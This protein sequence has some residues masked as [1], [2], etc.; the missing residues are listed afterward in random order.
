MT[1]APSPASPATGWTLT[2]DAWNRLVKVANGTTT[3]AEY[4]YDGRN[5]RTVKMKYS[6][7][8]LSETRHFYYNDG[9]QCLEERVNAG[10]TAACQYV[11]GDRYVDDLVLRDRDSDYAYGVDER[12]Y[13]MQDPNWNVIALGETDGDV[14]QRFSYKAYG[15]PEIRRSNFVPYG[16]SYAWDILYTGRHYDLE[17]GRYHYRNRYHHAQLGRFLSRDPI[18]Y[19]SKDFNLYRYVHNSPTNS[20]DPS[21]TSD[22]GWPGPPLSCPSKCTQADIDA[23]NAGYNQCVLIVYNTYKPLFDNWEKTRD[24]WLAEAGKQESQCLANCKANHPDNGG[25]RAACQ[26]GCWFAY[27]ALKANIWGAWSA[28][29][30][31]LTAQETADYLKCGY[32]NPCHGKKAGDIK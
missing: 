27:K 3:I 16:N 17:T 10:T 2:Y 26:L 1:T 21:G 8:Q 30:A 5:F 19:E 7:G 11:W 18:G 24:L 22:I 6:S 20:F 32:D 15:Q 9:W 12:L 13:A 23:D 31:A 14:A 25:A 28:G 29:V 4:Q